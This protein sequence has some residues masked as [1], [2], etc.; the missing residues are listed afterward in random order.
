MLNRVSPPWAPGTWAETYSL[1]PITGQPVLVAFNAAE[2]A[3]AMERNLKTPAEY[4][5][6]LMAV[7]R[8]IFG[9]AVPQPV[10]FVVTAWGK[11]EMAYGS[12]S[13]TRLAPGGSPAFENAHRK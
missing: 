4:R 12:Y 5:A 3:W 8:S 7:L 10:S 11:D 2:A 1:L 6:Q 13:Y 9:P